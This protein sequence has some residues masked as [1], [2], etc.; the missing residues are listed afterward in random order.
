M[1]ARRPGNLLATDSREKGIKFRWVK[2]IVCAHS[3]A[4]IDS[5]GLNDRDGFRDIAGME[6]AARK[7]GIEIASRMR[8]LSS[9]SCVRPVPPSSLTSRSRLPESSKSVLKGIRHS[10]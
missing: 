3:A 9:Q 7:I 1:T 2:V 5:E 6:A 10:C 8:R 4:D